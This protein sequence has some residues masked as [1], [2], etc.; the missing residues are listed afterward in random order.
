MRTMLA[1]AVLS[2]LSAAQAESQEVAKI[3]IAV[4]RLDRLM[5]NENGG[6]DR[7][8]MLFGDKDILEGLKKINAEIKSTQQEILGVEDEIQLAEMGK[9]IEFLNRKSNLLRQ[10]MNNE[11]GGDMQKFVREFVI[12][13][14]RDQYH[15]IAQDAGLRS[16]SL[17][18]QCRTRGHHRGCC[19]E[20]QRLSRQ[21]TGRI[22][23]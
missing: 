5:N 11:R 12:K 1:V 16:F 13:T 23:L 18:G 2:L 14:Y 3:K 10:R 15:M 8:R 4:V 9:R 17:Q 21:D 20:V 22:T 19:R 7:M 6:Y